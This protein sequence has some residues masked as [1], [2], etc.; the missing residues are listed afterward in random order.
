VT[1]FAGDR[2]YVDPDGWVDAGLQALRWLQEGYAHAEVF[3]YNPWGHA[4]SQMYPRGA[5]M[6]PIILAL[7]EKNT[8]FFSGEKVRRTIYVYNHTF[9]DKEFTLKVRLANERKEIFSKDFPV[10]LIGGNWVELNI[11]IPL[12]EV[13]TKQEY[14]FT[15]K[16]FENQKEATDGE[17]GM[18][19]IFPKLSSADWPKGKILVVTEPK[20]LRELHTIGLP[21]QARKTINQALSLQPDMILV[22]GGNV[23]PAEGIE[24]N[25]YVSHGGRVIL[26]NVPNGSWLPGG[27]V[28]ADSG[29]HFST[30]AFFAVN[31]HP[32]LEGLNAQDV[33]LWRSDTYACRGTFSLPS[34]NALKTILNA[35]GMY[36]IQWAPLLELPYGK[37]RFVLNQMNVVG[38]ISV[39]PAAGYLLKNMVHAVLPPMENTSGP[40]H[41]VSSE[42]SPLRSYITA[43]KFILSDNG[44]LCLIDGSVAPTMEKL[45][46]LV[47]RKGTIILHRLTPDS[48]AVISKTLGIPIILEAK[49]TGQVIR[50]GR[51]PI[52]DGLSNDDFFWMAGQ[53]GID[54][55]FSPQLKATMP[56]CEYVLDTKRSPGWRILTAPAALA[57]YEKGNLRV[58]LDQLCWDVGQE[59]EKSRRLRI[60][61]ALLTNL[62]AKIEDEESSKLR[63]LAFIDL[64]SVVNRGFVDPVEGDGQGGWTDEG[65]K[66]DMRFFPVNLVGT[67]R[68]GLGCPKEQFPER[69]SMGGCEFKLINPEANHGKSCLVI[70]TGSGL[71]KESASIPVGQ[72]A[73]A[74]WFLHTSAIGWSNPN[75]VEVAKITVHYADG[76]TAILAF[77]N[78][79]H[80][81]DWRDGSPAARAQTA[82]RGYC[83][84]HEPAVVHAYRWENPNPQKQIRNLTVTGTYGVYILIGLTLEKE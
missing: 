41:I 2:A 68:N 79:I 42:K 24:L 32:L 27:A 44:N 49:N 18:W 50:T 47:G 15:A 63:T 16:L 1:N 3:A 9:E 12:P 51:D 28:I 48:A 62:G 23:S 55:G 74:V 25:R 40:L 81:T 57:V 38:R 82:W 29:N 7:R 76:T 83:I 26:T 67:D 11:D 54:E 20:N 66:W 64:K 75:P 43:N 35:G 72:V 56:I 58:V 14:R 34:G 80:L 22:Y 53:F 78:Q 73:R 33:Q 60:G 45:S 52:I 69:S 8:T 37:G 21:F 4:L 17:Q 77:Q 31:I 59:Q 39:E 5:V 6:R 71:S 19:S 13:P 10:S 84:R 65:P 36:G 61:T 70:G 30:H 46:A